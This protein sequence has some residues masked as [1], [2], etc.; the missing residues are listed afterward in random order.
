MTDSDFS[1]KGTVFPF[2]ACS[3]AEIE[4]TTF[5]KPTSVMNS[6]LFKFGM[7]DHSAGGGF[8]GGICSNV[9]SSCFLSAIL[10]AACLPAAVMGLVLDDDL[11]DI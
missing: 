8:G 3:L 10:A 11:D 9:F 4:S 5:S 2:F 7:N 6:V 1:I